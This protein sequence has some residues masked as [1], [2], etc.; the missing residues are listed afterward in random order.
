MRRIVLRRKPTRAADT[1]L[2]KRNTTNSLPFLLQ[3]GA[4]K[5]HFTE[6]Q[7]DKLKRCGICAMEE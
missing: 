4:K 6:N 3:A 5:L 2:R 1:V 7:Y